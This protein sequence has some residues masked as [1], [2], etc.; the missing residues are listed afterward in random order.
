RRVLA[1]VTAAVAEPWT[2]EA[3]R[4]KEFGLDSIATTIE[5]DP[6]HRARQIDDA[7]HEALGLPRPVIGEARRHV[8][9]A[10]ESP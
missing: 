10:T 3:N 6:W 5:E 4:Q 8:T 1:F 9:L 2:V 7:V